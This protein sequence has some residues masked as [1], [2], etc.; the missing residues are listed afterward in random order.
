MY[1]FAWNGEYDEDI[2]DHRDTGQWKFFVVSAR[3]LPDQKSIG[4]GPLRR[5]CASSCILR[6][7]AG[8]MAAKLPAAT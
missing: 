3:E 5:L 1:I 7:L 8:L 2:A 6:D 4:L